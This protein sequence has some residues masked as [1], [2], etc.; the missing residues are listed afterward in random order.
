MLNRKCEQCN[1]H[2]K[3]VTEDDM[4]CDKCTIQGFFNYQ[5]ISRKNIKIRNWENKIVAKKHQK[6]SRET[7]KRLDSKCV[8]C[9]YFNTLEEK[10]AY[11]K[12]KQLR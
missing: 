9:I 11:E 2:F 6:L 10:E 5:K 4:V 3:P 7:L 1:D 8:G 12:K